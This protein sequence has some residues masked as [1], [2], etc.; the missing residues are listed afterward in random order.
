[1]EIFLPGASDRARER[2]FKRGCKTLEKQAAALC[3]WKVFPDTNVKKLK[4]GS[5]LS[6][7]HRAD[8]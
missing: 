4:Y 6:P 7:P 5:D 1:M 8:Y 3:V 2:D